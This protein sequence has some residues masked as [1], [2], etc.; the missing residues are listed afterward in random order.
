MRVRAHRVIA[1]LRQQWMG[2]L[3]LFLVL[4][5][6]VAYAADSVFSADIV[7]GEVKSADIGTAAVRSTD[8]GNSQVTSADVRDDTSRNGALGAVD[9]AASSV[10]SSEVEDESLTGDDIGNE[11]LDGADIEDQ[12]GVDTCTHGTERFG[13]LCAAV[14]NTPQ[15][16]RSARIMCADAE[17]RVP[18]LGEAEYLAANF[19]F[20]TLDTGEPFWTDESTLKRGPADGGFY[21]TPAAYTIDDD[22]SE[23]LADARPGEGEEHLTV[24]VTTPTN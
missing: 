16:W 14:D 18:T 10:G 12:S 4:T 13:E 19:D 8:I 6:G 1:H 15:T 22:G 17:L 5:G 23:Y 7:D 24:C 3:A 11:I 2:A 21:S 20:P 9:L